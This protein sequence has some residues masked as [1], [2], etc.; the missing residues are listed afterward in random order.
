MTHIFNK[1]D[2]GTLVFLV[3]KSIPYALRIA[4]CLALITG[5]L[6][7]QYYSLSV[8]PGLLLV[9][10]GSLLT[11]VKGYD[12]RLKMGKFNPYEKWESVSVEQVNAIPD[13]HKKMKKWDRS[14]LDISNGLG[15]LV[16]LAIAGLVTILFI[17]G[18]NDYNLSFIVFASNICALIVPHWVTGLRSILTIPLLIQKINI[19]K[20]LL[21]QFEENL[22]PFQIE[23]L[24]YLRGEE[25]QKSLP[26]DIKL[27]LTSSR[28]AE[29]FLGLYAQISM[30]D[31]NGTPYPYFYVVL[32]ANKG[33]GIREKIKN[34]SPPK[35]I[36]TE[37]SAK[38]DVE[39][40]VLR[41]YT[42]KTTGYHTKPKVVNQIF[43]E[44]LKLYVLMN[45]AI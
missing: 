17:I 37:L 10:A 14:A 20:S 7:L 30:N 15:F 33:F 22:L 35:G 2:R 34:Y 28:D 9:L 26:Q 1:S 38:K 36:I 3:F 44:G 31:V 12:N 5:G 39:V 29:G 45:K 21:N 43:A 23:H 32:V 24:V 18:F 11:L 8:F 19:F 4:L 6:A 25:E 16:F 41:Q 40:L 27:K 42:T 13:L